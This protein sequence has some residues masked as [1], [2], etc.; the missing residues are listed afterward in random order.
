[1]APNFI[2]SS[3]RVITRMG[4]RPMDNQIPVLGLD[5]NLLAIREA[6]GRRDIERHPNS[7]VISPFPRSD[8]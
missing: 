6:G 3:T 1:M 7:E 2:G 4:R 5:L 8:A